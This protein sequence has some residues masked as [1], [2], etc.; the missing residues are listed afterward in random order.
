MNRPHVHHGTEVVAVFHDRHEADQ[1]LDDLEHLDQL[2]PDHAHHLHVEASP[3]RDERAL[4]RERTLGRDLV[5][6]MAVMVPLCALANAAL[7]ATIATV[8][9][10]ADREALVLVG[11]PSGAVLGLLFG[12]LLGIMLA[13]RSLTQAEALEAVVLEDEDTVV[14]A[15]FDSPRR[16]DADRFDERVREILA[17]HHGALVSL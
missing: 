14:H 17:G 7:L 12:G 2:D 4:D 6:G 9:D 1:A 8:A 15:E 11:L 16:R 3:A 13:S 5:V 10:L